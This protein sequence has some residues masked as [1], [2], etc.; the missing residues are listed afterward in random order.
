MDNEQAKLILSAYRPGGQDASEPFFAEALE[1]ARLDPELG[2]WFTEQRRLDQLAH[3]A[4]RAQ[5]P[6]DGLR[7]SLLLDRKIVGTTPFNRLRV[8]PARLVAIAAAVIFLFGISLL[9]KPGFHQP[10]SMDRQ[11]FAEAIYE[12]KQEG[13]MSLGK[14]ASNPEE[15]KAWLAAK[16]SPHDFTIPGSLENMEGIGCQTFVLNGA[17]V[18]LLCFMLDKN[19]MV[20]LFVIDEGA[21][22]DPPGANPI[23][24]KKGNAVAATWSSGGRTFLMTGTN[25]DE[26]TLR[27]LI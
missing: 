1:Q 4:L 8:R 3:D 14:M 16:G 6:P 19:Q 21:I 7:E 13:K 12:L 20:H 24:T 27:R 22:T 11:Q 23:I 25:L 15:L 9:L 17:K 18:S 10:S 26:A 5:T 2:A